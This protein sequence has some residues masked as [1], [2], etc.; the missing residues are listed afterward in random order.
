LSTLEAAMTAEFPPSGGTV[1]DERRALALVAELRAEL[2]GLCPPAMR[3]P[4][5]AATLDMLAPSSIARVLSSV[6]FIW[7]LG[8]GFQGFPVVVV[9]GSGCHVFFSYFW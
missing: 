2:E 8:V 4:Q 5:E 3:E 1:A 7:I 6:G 9:G